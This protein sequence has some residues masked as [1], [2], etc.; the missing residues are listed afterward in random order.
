MQKLSPLPLGSGPAL[1]RAELD[2]NKYPCLKVGLAFQH[3]AAPKFISVIR[4]SSPSICQYLLT[5]QCKTN[6]PERA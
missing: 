1:L 3:A 4:H 2:A 5:P 6:Y